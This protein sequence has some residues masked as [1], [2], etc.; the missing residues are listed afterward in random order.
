MNVNVINQIRDEVKQ[1]NSLEE[2]DLYYNKHKADF[3]N[4]TTQ[5]LNRVYKIRLP[6]NTEY[7]ITKKNCVKKDG[8][9][10]NGEIN[11]KKVVATKNQDNDISELVYANINVDITNL[12]NELDSTKKRFEESL[13]LTTKQL[14]E[15]AKQI[16]AINE[17]I[18]IIPEIKNSLNEVI[19]V[20]NSHA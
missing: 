1:F 15:L 12:R 14:A 2:F 16:T 4:K 19:R 11:L 20:I 5:F 9:L 3:D 18:A 13:S 8:K 6:D 10:I 17:S 7:R